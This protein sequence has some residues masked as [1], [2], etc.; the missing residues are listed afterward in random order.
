MAKKSSGLGIDELIEAQQKL[1]ET[2][3][4]RETQEKALAQVAKLTKLKGDSQAVTLGDVRSELKGLRQD[5]KKTFNDDKPREGRPALPTQ[6]ANDASM[7]QTGTETDAERRQRLQK[8]SEVIGDKTALERGGSRNEGLTERNRTAFDKFIAESEKRDE[9][10]ADATKEQQELFSRLEETLTKLREAGSD[11][12]KQLIQELGKIRG[13][14]DVSADTDAKKKIQELAGGAERRATVGER[15]N[16]GSLGDAWAALTGKKSVMDPGG[17]K[18]GR[19]GGAASIVGNFMG[20]RLER[21]MEGQRSESMQRFFGAFR[22]TSNADARL[23]GQQ[24]ALQRNTG[25]AVAKKPEQQYATAK[26]KAEPM[27]AS[28]AANDPVVQPSAQIIA[29]PGMQARTEPAPTPFSDSGTAETA[30]KK[31]TVPVLQKMLDNMTDKLVTAIEGISGGGGLGS[32]LPDIDIGRRGP[33]VGGGGRGAPGGK[34][35]GKAP[36]KPG[37]GGRIVQGAKGVLGRA[38]TGIAN[39][40]KGA[41]GLIAGAG[42][43]GLGLLKGG[44]GVGLLGMGLGY[45][46]DAL[47]ESGHEKIGGATDVAANALTWGGT[48]AALG[49][50]IPGIGTAIGG[51]VGAIAGGAYGLYKNWGNLFGG[52]EKPAPAVVPPKP[53]MAVPSKAPTAAIIDNKMAT[54]T[55]LKTQQNNKPVIIQTGG[56][57]AP[58]PAPPPAIQVA[59]APVRN[60]ES[61]LEQYAARTSHFW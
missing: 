57:S 56:Q 18:M 7:P 40:A 49:S 30:E 6:A 36:G 60:S 34:A 9:L 13:E 20:E 50:F 42:K 37:L 35:P 8:L 22:P 14:L 43:A 17:N 52:D 3:P 51:G 19:L 61:A 45:G 24:D 39:V 10:M 5:I 12:S 31:L 4:D 41:G 32:L 54:N 29:F 47:K 27:R 48:G 16:Q 38:G 11:E 23:Q 59:R 1:A 15:G 53:V 2:A 33:I 28:A 21:S 44:L 46:A 58:P 25:S 55:E 26:P